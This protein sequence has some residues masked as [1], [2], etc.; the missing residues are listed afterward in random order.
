[1]SVADARTSQESMRQQ[2]LNPDQD[3]I[4]LGAGAARLR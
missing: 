1:M 3:F 4:E 2:S